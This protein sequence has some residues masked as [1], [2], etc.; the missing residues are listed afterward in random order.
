MSGAI[1]RSTSTLA[2]SVSIPLR[3]FD[4]NQGEKLRT[5]LDID[6]NRTAE[7]MRRE[8]QV[9]SDVDSAYATVSSTVV[10]LQPYKDHY[11]QA[12]RRVRDTISFSY[13]HGAASLLD[14]LN[15]QADYRSVQAQLPEPD[16]LVSEGRQPIE[17][18]GRT[19]GHPMKHLS[20][21]GCSLAVSAVVHSSRR[22][23]RRQGRSE[24]GS[25]AA[26]EGRAR[27]GPQLCFRWIIPSS[28]PLTTGG[29]TCRAA[30]AA[31]HGRSHSGHFAERAGHFARVRARCGDR[32]APGRHRQERP[33]PAAR[34]KRGHLRRVFRLSEGGGR[35]AAGAHATGAR[36]SCCTTRA[37]SR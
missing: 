20:A 27:P 5:Q 34:A 4:R 18:C 16:R 9:F 12:G 21:R 7:R 23:R 35:R 3:I 32:R 6:R 37:P 28:F 1:R 30:S 14:F 25:A 17:S 24:G 29:R 26:A 10:L 13:Q 8:A 22:L 31:G 2:F 15:A 33:T 11:L 19:R 36:A